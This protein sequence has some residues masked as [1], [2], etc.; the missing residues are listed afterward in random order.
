ME[1]IR[2]KS[3]D[4]MQNF[5]KHWN[6]R[7]EP[8]KLGRYPPIATRRCK[9]IRSDDIAIRAL[10]FFGIDSIMVAKELVWTH[11]NIATRVTS[12]KHPAD[13][14]WGYNGKMYV[15][16]ELVPIY[17]KE[18][19]KVADILTPNQYE[20]ELLTGMKIASEEDAVRVIDYLHKEG[21]KIV[22][23]SSTDLGSDD[24]LISSASFATVHPFIYQCLANRYV[25]QLNK[26][27]YT[28]IE[29]Q[30]LMA[31]LL[32]VSHGMDQSPYRHLLDPFLWVDVSE[33]FTR[34]ACTL[35]GLSIDSPLAVW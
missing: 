23:L 21:V 12:R 8:S 13:N 31:T 19:V 28:I 34:D 20:A 27:F 11:A 32:Y 2:A 7:M 26:G 30:L 18:E 4:K 5:F 25:N 16:K 33:T 24:E 3:G 35:L 29:F 10:A 1:I 9:L 14:C 6:I 15:P 17:A 22:V